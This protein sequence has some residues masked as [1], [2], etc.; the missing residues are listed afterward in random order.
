[1]N[2]DC[3]GSPATKPVDTSD[4]ANSIVSV[5]SFGRFLFFDG[6]DLTWNTEAGLACPSKRVPSVDVYQVNHHGLDISNNPLLLRALQ[7]T[8]AVFNNGPRKGCMP[9]VAKNL[10]ALSP[11]PVIFQVHKNQQDADANAPAEF[12][13]NVTAEGGN[14]IKLA[15]T[16]D[17]KSYTVSI[18]ATGFSRTFNTRQ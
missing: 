3:N 13:A 18:P 12:C 6:G 10:R 7:P 5:L 14:Y 2:P 11:P 1:M 15:V 8:V 9:E 4:N 17:A 16:P